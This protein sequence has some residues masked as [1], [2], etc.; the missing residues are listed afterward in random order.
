MRRMIITALLAWCGGLAT[1]A[2]SA[3]GYA[4][5]DAWKGYGDEFQL[6]YVVGYLDAATLVKR[7]DQRVFVPTSNKPDYLRWRAMVNDY[8][9][10]PANAKRS[11]PEAM[12]TAGKQI[13]EEILRAYRKRM[14]SRAAPLASPS[15]PSPGS[16]STDPR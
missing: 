6:G 2:A 14:E 13:Q 10:N 1:A 9:A 11:V 3:Y 12:A 15:P 5:L 4:M 7:H 16:A 8:Y